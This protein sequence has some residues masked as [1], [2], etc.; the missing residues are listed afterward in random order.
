MLI[1][2]SFSKK[3]KTWNLVT[4]PRCTF[5]M[6]LI[7]SCSSCFTTL[8]PVN[9]WIIFVWN[10]NVQAQQNFV[11]QLAI[12]S[13][14]LSCLRSVANCWL[15]AHFS[16][17]HSIIVVQTAIIALFTTYRMFLIEDFANVNENSTKIVG[18]GRLIKHDKKVDKLRYHGNAFLLFIYISYQIETFKCQFYI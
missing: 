14:F 15:S 4:N 18:Y 8:H 7:K 6:F 9:N 17:M 11:S 1:Y 5:F 16:V 10:T 3:G 13:F 2:Y 12:L